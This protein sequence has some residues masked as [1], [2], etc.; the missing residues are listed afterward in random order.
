MA[1]DIQKTSP[2][3]TI[4]T[5]SFAL[6]P[7]QILLL[8]ESFGVLEQQ[9]A[10]AALV[11][12]QHVFALDP[13]LRGLFHTSIELQGRK[14]MEALEYTI[15]TFENPAEVV[16]MLEAMGRRHVTY[17]VRDEHYATMKQAMLQTLRETLGDDFNRAAEAAWSRALGF[18]CESMIQG[19]SEVQDLLRGD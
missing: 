4:P 6:T 18:I 1:S 17:G 10:I 5:G 7:G 15:A 12:Y 13:S 16:P 11:F 3:G 8:R 19:A 14:L 2:T 9:S